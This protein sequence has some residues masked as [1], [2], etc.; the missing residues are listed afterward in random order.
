[1]QQSTTQHKL[2]VLYQHGVHTTIL[3]HWN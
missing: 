3:I 2:K 1:M